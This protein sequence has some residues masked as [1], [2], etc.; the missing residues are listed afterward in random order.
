MIRHVQPADK[1]MALV[2]ATVDGNVSTRMWYI[3]D[4]FVEKCHSEFFKSLIT[5]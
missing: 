5:K 4:E 2:C 1:K 3:I